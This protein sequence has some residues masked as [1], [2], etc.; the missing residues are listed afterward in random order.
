MSFNQSALD[1]GQ[2]NHQVDFV[3]LKSV[4]YLGKKSGTIHLETKPIDN[5]YDPPICI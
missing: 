2:S 5:A 4:L 1:S 3:S